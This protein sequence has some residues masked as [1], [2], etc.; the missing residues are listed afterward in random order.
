MHYTMKMVVVLAMSASLAA[1]ADQG[2]GANKETGGGLVGAGL[3]GLAGSQLGSGSGKL[4]TTAIGV[5]LGALAGTSVGKSLDRADQAA[6]DRTAGQAFES[7]PTGQ[8][9]TWRN[10]DTGHS[11]TITPTQT[12]MQ[13][14]GQVCREFQQTI[15]VGGQ[16]QQGVG[17]ACRQPDGT[18]RVVSG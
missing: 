17:T 14:N 16:T 10:P 15:V 18:W 2:F 9:S 13:P 4:A 12:V 11:G 6:A 5:L 3:G 1:C 8:A 7:N